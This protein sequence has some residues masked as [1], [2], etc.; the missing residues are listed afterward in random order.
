MDTTTVVPSA[1]I[2]YTPRTTASTTAS[3]NVPSTM[4]ASTSESHSV[5][6]PSKVPDTRLPD[7]SSMASSRPE[8]PTS[9]IDRTAVL[10]S[11]AT[12][13][14]SRTTISTTASQNVPST[15]TSSTIESQSI[16][17][18]S[19]VPDTRHEDPSSTAPSRSE[20]PTN[21]IDTTTAMPSP[22]TSHTSR[23][24]VYTTASQNVPSTTTASTNL[25]QS[26]HN[27][28]TVPDTG[29]RNHSSRDWN[30]LSTS[31]IVL[32]T[33]GTLLATL[34]QVWSQQ[35]TGLNA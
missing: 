5:H 21:T 16:H 29:R 4:T 10:L 8:L 2:T 12:K 14:T 35:D 6:N 28:S 9:T 1:V 7:P 17:K 19:T 30:G 18:P 3:Q 26:V 25:A 33:V 11:L 20:L 27:L 34:L 13:H 23:H 24:T 32:I 22:V 31:A 15:M